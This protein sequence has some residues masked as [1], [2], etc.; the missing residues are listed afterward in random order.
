M[1]AQITL[2]E[3]YAISILKQRGLSIRAIARELSRSPSTI[4]RELSRN[5]TRHDGAY[6]WKLADSYSRTR[7]SRSRRNT[8]FRNDDW[9][10]VDHLISL[11]WSPEQVAGWLRLHGLLSISYETIYLYVWDDKAAGGDLWRHM[12]QSTKKR[13]KRSG[14]R[15][16]RGRLAGKRHISERPPEVET[17]ET[18]T[19][20]EIDTIKGDSQG[21]HSVLTL[22]ERKTGFT[23]M[24]KLERRCAADTTA[25]CI[26]L[27]RRHEGRVATIT[28]DNGT[29]FH[30]YKDVET[31]T[32]V[33]FYFATPHHSWERGTNENT[34][35]LIRQYLPRRRSMAH[36]TQLH[37]DEVA[38]MLNSRPRKRLGYR[39]PEECYVPAR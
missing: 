16:S 8:R 36:V 2:H 37:C 26:D 28:S 27:I 25:R 22:V 14:S 34:N 1:S 39:T 6:R 10:T 23:M 32:G 38:A 30:G 33:E 13:R 12:R 15:D 20:W 24:G 29:E 35:G 7:R 3:R 11:D 18:D 5:R 19:H 4:S 31:A 17:R 9:A 21:K